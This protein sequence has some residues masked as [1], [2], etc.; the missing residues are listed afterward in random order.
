MIRRG[1]VFS[2]KDFFF[3]L[4]ALLLPG[5]VV[6]SDNQIGTQCQMRGIFKAFD[7]SVLPE[8]ARIEN[9]G[10]RDVQYGRSAL[11]RVFSFRRG[12]AEA[13]GIQPGDRALSGQAGLYRESEVIIRNIF[14]HCILRSCGKKWEEWEIAV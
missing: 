10:E 7:A 3:S 9:M 2:R 13:Q 8:P 6:V 11:I 5:E 12:Q 14:R 4:A 1:G